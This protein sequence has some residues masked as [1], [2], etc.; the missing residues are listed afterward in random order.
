[1][2]YREHPDDLLVKRNGL[3]RK[4]LPGKRGWWSCLFVPKAG[5]HAAATIA[6]ENGNTKFD[7][8]WIGLPVEG[9]G[10]SNNPSM[11]LVPP[12]HEQ[13]AFQVD[14]GVRR[15]DIRLKY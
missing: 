10:V 5:T 9:F 3:F 7:K 11:F 6:D 15:I 14:S 1:M 13:A 8:N 2:L 12:S 4:R